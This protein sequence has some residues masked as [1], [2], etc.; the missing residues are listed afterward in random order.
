MAGL[1]K[2]TD[3]LG[4]AVRAYRTSQTAVPV[5][6][7]PNRWFLEPEKNE[8]M[9]GLVER[10]LQASGIPREQFTSGAFADPRTGEIL[11]GRI[12]A[13]GVVD[14][15][16][17]RRPFMAVE[18]GIP[19][20]SDGPLLDSNL[21]RRKG[22]WSS[23]ELDQPFI[24]TLEGPGG[25]HFYGR[26]IDYQVP[27]L[28]RNNLGQKNP[29]LRPR[30]RGSIYGVGDQYQVWTNAGKE[31]AVYDLLRVLSR[32]PAGPR[33]PGTKTEFGTLL[34]YGLLAPVA[35]QAFSED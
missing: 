9:Q 31:H 15:F 16:D 19:V 13:S 29:T 8:R 18:Q 28:L 1:Q 7:A 27:V 17:G 10:V 26:G 4:E 12:F 24:A 25:K 23:D 2:F 3:S 5:A 21:V 33:A 11:D 22:L 20:A 32:D 14:S 30:A 34:R 6:P 35:S